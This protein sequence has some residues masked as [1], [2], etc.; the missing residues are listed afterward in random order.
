MKIESEK[1]GVLGNLNLAGVSLSKSIV[2]Y[3]MA[4]YE[5]DVAKCIRLTEIDSTGKYGNSYVGIPVGEWFTITIEFYPYFYQS[6]VS[7]IVYLNGNEIGRGKTYYNYGTISAPYK[8]FVLT[9]VSDVKISLD[10]VVAEV[11]EKTFIDSNGSAVKNP[12][13]TLPES[14]K[15]SN[16]PAENVHNGVFDFEK[17]ALGTPAVPGLITSVNRADYGNNLDITIDPKDAANKV[18]M[19]KVAAGSNGNSEIFTVSN[20]SPADANCYVYE[21]DMLAS[22][23]GTSIAQIGVRGKIGSDYKNIFQAAIYIKGDYM[24][25]NGGTLTVLAKNDAPN[26]SDYKDLSKNPEYA[27]HNKTIIPALNVYGWVNIRFEVYPAENI[28]KIYID[29]EFRAETESVYSINVGYDYTNAHL[30]TTAGSTMTMYLDNVRAEKITKNYRTDTCDD[31]DAPAGK[32]YDP[33]K[34][35]GSSGVTPS[36][37]EDTTS[38]VSGIYDFQSEQIGTFNLDGVTGEFPV[39]YAVISEDPENA[40][41]RLLVYRTLSGAKETLSFTSGGK[42]I[43][44]TNTLI[45]EWDM[46]MKSI[47]STGDILNIKIGSAYLLTIAAD[48]TS[49]YSVYESSSTKTD[50]PQ[51]H[52]NLLKSDLEIGKWYTVRVEY[53]V[54]DG[55]AM[56]KVY[57]DNRLLTVSDNHLNEMGNVHAPLM[58]YSALTMTSI[59]DADFNM[60]LDNVSAIRSDETMVK[61]DYQIE[62]NQTPYVNNGYFQDENTDGTKLGYDDLEGAAI[63]SS[64]ILTGDSYSGTAFNATVT[65]G[66]LSFTGQGVS[67]GLKNAGNKEGASYVFETDL[68]L[69]GSAK[70]NTANNFAWFGM[71]ASGVAKNNYFLYLRFVYDP[72]ENGNIKHVRIVDQ[73][74]SVGTVATLN[75]GEMYNVRFVYTLDN[76]YNDDGSLNKYRGYVEV[77]VDNVLVKSYYTSGAGDTV[78][79]EQFNCVGF[80]LR[81]YSNSNIKEMTYYLDNTFIG[82]V[83]E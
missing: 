35:Y 61:T 33:S 12:D 24:S 14:G 77:Y 44:A 58:S 11:I 38:S 47:G 37:P 54:F 9:T 25:E 43:S 17:T 19:H 21:F 46:Y 72:D 75:Y 3:E 67:V 16:T 66:A 23:T 5:Y 39:G 28:A 48:S 49:S 36:V 51:T 56:I 62:V 4:V 2:A 10:D 45:A 70:G 65:D 83:N 69:I 76:V 64:N 81:G 8:Q 18:L 15:S 63:N 6:D 32:D 55:R 29:D 82:A 57:I 74:S 34:D 59:A 79:N 30:F 52:R 13:V 40:V 53:A 31:I 50:F 22:A 1:F 71:S 27:F 73:S 68:L 20:Q 78:S 7:S 41:Q 80:E 26:I 60:R 42:D